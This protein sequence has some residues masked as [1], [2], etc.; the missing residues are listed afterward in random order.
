MAEAPIVFVDSD[1]VTWERVGPV[2]LK[3][4]AIGIEDGGCCHYLTNGVDNYIWADGVPIRLTEP[5]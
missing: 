3:A 1:T 4:H 5:E 2:R